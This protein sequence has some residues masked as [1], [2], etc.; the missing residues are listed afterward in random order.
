MSERERV[1][2]VRP[3]GLELPTFWFVVLGSK[4]PSRFFGVA[5]EPRAPFKP[6]SIVRRLSA[7]QR[8]E[9]TGELAFG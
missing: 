9:S 1:S 5:Y 2:M 4:I 3:G 8:S 7:I 6:S